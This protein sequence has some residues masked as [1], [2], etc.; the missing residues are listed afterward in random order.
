MS[1]RTSFS[2][3]ALSFNPFN[4]KFFPLFLSYLWTAAEQG[5]Q[6]LG[7]HAIAERFVEST[8]RKH[9]CTTKKK[10]GE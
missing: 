7:G 2:L 3:D 5:D 9:C 8:E 6:E 10:G 1:M 4:V